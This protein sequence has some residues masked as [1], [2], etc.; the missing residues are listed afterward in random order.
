LLAIF[1]EGLRLSFFLLQTIFRSNHG[2]TKSAKPAAQASP[3]HGAGHR[4][5]ATLDFG[6]FRHE[7]EAAAVLPHGGRFKLKEYAAGD[8]SPSPPAA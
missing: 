1:G 8:D 2:G 7:L 4:P 5:V 6:N 3:D